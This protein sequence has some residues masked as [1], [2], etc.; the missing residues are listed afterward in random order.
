MVFVLKNLIFTL[1][2][3][4]FEP[5]KNI[6]NENKI[7]LVSTIKGYFISLRE[8]KV[9]REWAQWFSLIMAIIFE[10]YISRKSRL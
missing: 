7:I 5:R 3:Y 4:V 2:F 1:L 10:K 9:R 6:K 8:L